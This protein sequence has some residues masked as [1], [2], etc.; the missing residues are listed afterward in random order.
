MERI[1][2][3]LS[4]SYGVNSLS[5]YRSDKLENLRSYTLE[6]NMLMENIWRTFGDV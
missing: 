3:H 1:V 6:V 5:V 4:F 2:S